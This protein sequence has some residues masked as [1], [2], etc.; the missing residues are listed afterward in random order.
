M[1]RLHLAAQCKAAG[2]VFS[3]VV[4]PVAWLAA[5]V[6]IA[7]ENRHDCVGGAGFQRP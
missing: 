5:M 4:S 6:V 3:D 1:R 2:H 7:R